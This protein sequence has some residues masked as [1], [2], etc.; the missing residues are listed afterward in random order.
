MEI[1]NS[2][3]SLIRYTNLI[4]FFLNNIDLLNNDVQK[5][6][7]YVVVDYLEQSNFGLFFSHYLNINM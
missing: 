3:K 1:K 4:I 7:E 5:K 6:S 2:N